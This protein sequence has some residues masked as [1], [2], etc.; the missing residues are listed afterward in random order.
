MTAPLRWPSLPRFVTWDSCGMS[1]VFRRRAGLLVI[2]L[3]ACP[4]A[5]CGAS[6]QHRTP[7]SVHPGSAA[8]VHP[9]TAAS[10]H[11][12]TRS[13]GPA[14]G[15]DAKT[16]PIVV[17]RQGTGLAVY[18]RVL[19][20]GR[21]FLLKLDT[22]A[23]RSVI[24]TAL[25]QTLGLSRDGRSRTA[26][27]I[28][29]QTASQPVTI[30]R[31]AIAHIPLP[32]MTI[33]SQ[34]TVVVGPRIGGMPVSGLLGSDVLA[35]FGIVTLN[36]P[37]RQLILRSGVPHGGKAI[38]MQVHHGKLGARYETTQVKIGRA[39]TESWLLDTGAENTL[40]VAATPAASGLP[41]AGPLIP[42]Q[43]AA[44]CLSQVRPVAINQW[45]AGGLKL[46]P[47]TALSFSSSSGSLF[48]PTNIAGAVGADI[49][50][51]FKTATF[52]FSAD[53]VILGGELAR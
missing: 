33:S 44:G 18:V 5:G 25:A 32:Q 42:V 9:G 52:D 21:T 27:T 39:P 36:F 19:I 8:S 13:A 3:L 11:R 31:W 24:S 1:G 50:G 20:R 34:N 30:S 17:R 26:S 46:A 6:A 37:A 16:V 43:G 28:G 41:Q 14:S 40:I 10:V 38:V 45:T 4:L 48:G 47:A 22:G 51:R 15:G 49:L 12:G 35:R 23:S 53:R 7:A 29:C 2:G